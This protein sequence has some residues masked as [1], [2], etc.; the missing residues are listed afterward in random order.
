MVLTETKVI[1]SIPM[2]GGAD[3]MAI[4]P[5]SGYGYILGM[6]SGSYRTIIISGTEIITD[7]A[8]FAGNA[9]GVNPVTGYVYVGN[10][11]D[12]RVVV[13][14]GTRAIATLPVA[15][16]TGIGV[17][18]KTGYVYF[19]GGN[20]LTV[21]SATTVIT[22]LPIFGK[23]VSIGVNPKTGYRVCPRLR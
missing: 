16:V 7:S 15:D 22:T 17:N 9:V 14:T 19:G 1:T 20:N 21:V 5:Q 2:Y 8:G 3:A 12:H 11:V 23:Y 18:P 13:V 6:W 10:T 4:N